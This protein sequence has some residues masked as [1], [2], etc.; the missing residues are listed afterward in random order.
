[1]RAPPAD[2]MRKMANACRSSC[3]AHRGNG[4]ALKPRRRLRQPGVHGRSTVTPNVSPLV[5]NESQPSDVDISETFMPLPRN[6]PGKKK[7]KITPDK[8]WM[9]IKIS[10]P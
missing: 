2:I 10:H 5:S 3:A 7:K 8:Y 6:P 9:G 4:R 1:M